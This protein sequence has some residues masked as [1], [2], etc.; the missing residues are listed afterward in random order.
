MSKPFKERNRNMTKSIRFALLAVAASAALAFAGS[1]F[2]SFTPKLW[3]SSFDSLIGNQTFELALGQDDVATAKAQIYVGA[4]DFADVPGGVTGTQIGTVDA[5]VKALALG[6]AILPLPGKVEVSDSTVYPA[7]NTCTSGATS[8]TATWVLVLTAP[9]GTELRV[10]MYVDNVPAAQ[11]PNPQLGKYKISV[12]LPSPY[13]DPSVGGATF[14]AKLIRATITMTNFLT[15]VDNPWTAIVTPYVENTGTANPAGTV[16]TQSV[17]TNGYINALKAKLIKKKS[18]TK[19]KYFA[20]VSGVVGAGGDNVASDVKIY[21]AKGKKPGKKLKTTKSKSSGVFS[22]LIPLK[23]TMAFYVLAS[24]AR[25]DVTP[26]V[27]DPNLE[28]A[29]G[30]PMP[31]TAVTT[32]GFETAGITKKVKRPR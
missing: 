11:P 3:A 4:F 23:K 1:A 22:A 31:C 30:V 6:G 7:N 27:C 24:K 17:V 28:L 8:H 26:P 16:E 25:G 12:C 9:T 13:I 2:A 20:K 14:G 15:T 32:S 21:Q 29:P 10:P 19:I 5:S 18:G